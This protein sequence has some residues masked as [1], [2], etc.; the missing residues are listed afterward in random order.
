MSR[1]PLSRQLRGTNKILSLSTSPRQLKSLNKTVASIKHTT[2]ASAF[3][4]LHSS[5]QLEDKLSVYLRQTRPTQSLK[6]VHP[7][8]KKAISRATSPS[9]MAFLLPGL[10]R[11]L[12]LTTPFVLAAPALINTYRHPIRCDAANPLSR[13]THDYSREAQT[14]V[15]KTSGAPN[16]RAIRQISMGSI[17]GVVAGLG[18]SVFSKPLAVLIGLGIVLVQVCLL[19]CSD[20]GGIHST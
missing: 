7:T 20:F 6:Q 19:M 15:I 17:F 5:S 9:T 12:I 10:R 4:G 2:S 11:G 8:P 18:V 1:V 14:P 16:P 3:T 13:L